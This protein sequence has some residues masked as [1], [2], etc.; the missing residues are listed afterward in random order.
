M[1]EGAG[2]SSVSGLYKVASSGAI[3]ATFA[4]LSVGAYGIVVAS[5]SAGIGVLVDCS[6]AKRFEIVP[7]LASG[8]YR[9]YVAVYDAAGGLITA[10]GSVSTTSALALSGSVFMPTVSSIGPTTILL[11]A[12]AKQVFIGI[13]AHTTPLEMTA[14]DVYALPYNGVNRPAAPLLVPAI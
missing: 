4:N 14:F 1:D 9:A 5:A 12:D 3:A 6:V 8:T 7:S 11:S 10:T 2:V 13:R